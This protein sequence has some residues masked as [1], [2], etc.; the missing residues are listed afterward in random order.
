MAGGMPDWWDW[1]LDLTPHLLKRMVD[2]DFSEVDLRAMLEK[3]AGWRED[4]VEG[5]WVIESSHRRQAWE[6][7]VEPDFEMGLLAVI[8]A[9]A[10]G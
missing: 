7:I 2:R 6:V 3:A 10:V 4:T 1:E 5:R 9:Y 8:T